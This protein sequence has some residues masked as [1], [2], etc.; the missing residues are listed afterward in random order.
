MTD[1]D[2][3][4]TAHC[5][6]VHTKEYVY[7][8]SAA[9]SNSF[10]FHGCCPLLGQ[11]FNILQYTVCAAIAIALA[12]AAVVCLAAPFDAGCISCS[13]AT[14]DPGQDNSL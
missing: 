4:E 11:L 14:A 8:V 13:A 12:A 5:C 10:F 9:D 2:S 7:V 1:S 3:G 6:T